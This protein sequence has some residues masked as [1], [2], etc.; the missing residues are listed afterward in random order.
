MATIFEN[1]QNSNYSR[2]RNTNIPRYTTTKA[3]R[4]IVIFI[5]VAVC[6]IVLVM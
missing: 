3:A 2:S 4:W 5:I 1:N 6:I